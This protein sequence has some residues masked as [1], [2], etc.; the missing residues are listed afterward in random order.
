MSKILIENGKVK[1]IEYED[2]DK[3]AHQIEADNVV[4]ATGGFS[5]DLS[6]TS[7]LRKYRPDLVHFP[8]SNGAQTTGDGQ[9]LPNVMLMPN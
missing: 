7:L 3:A 8:L 6:A 9:K 1:G 2:K 4:L 5:A